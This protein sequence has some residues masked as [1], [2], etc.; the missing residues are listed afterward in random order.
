MN[1]TKIGDWMRTLPR[2]TASPAFASEVR[3]K[4]RQDERQ[5]P[6]VW[7]FAAAFAMAACLVAVVQ[8][9]IAQQERRQKIELRAERQKLEAELEAVKKIATEAEP[10]VVLEDGRGT[11]VIVD[12]DA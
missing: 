3:R 12:L 1:E 2:A 9:A 4:I 5:Q 6:V 11:R 10:V 8:L 7:R